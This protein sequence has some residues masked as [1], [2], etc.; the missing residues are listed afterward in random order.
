MTCRLC[1]HEFCWLCLE[2]WKEH[3]QKTGGYYQCNKYEELKKK[4]DGK[5]NKEE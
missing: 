5:I 1:S 3:G 4:G 2:D